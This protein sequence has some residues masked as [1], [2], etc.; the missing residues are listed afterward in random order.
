MHELCKQ[1]QLKIRQINIKKVV[2]ISSDHSCYSVIFFFIFVPLKSKKM[3]HRSGILTFIFQ[4]RGQMICKFCKEKWLR[5]D[6]RKMAV[7]DIN[8]KSVKR[9]SRKDISTKY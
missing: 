4:I 9:N 6:F 1:N 7:N 2:G 3:S 8:A 5:T